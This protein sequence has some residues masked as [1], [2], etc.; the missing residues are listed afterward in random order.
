MKKQ[1]QNKPNFKD[2]QMNLKFCKKMPYENK[3]NWTLGEN[4]PNQTQFQT[5]FQPLPYL[6]KVREEKNRSCRLLIKPMLPLYKPGNVQYYSRHNCRCSSMV[7][8]SF[9]KAGVEGSTP[10]IGCGIWR[11]RTHSNWEINYG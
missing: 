2:A 7:E 1:S 6:P 9:R 3:D 8:H 10:S 5:Q 4:K 11:E